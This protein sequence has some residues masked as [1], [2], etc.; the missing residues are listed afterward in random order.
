MRSTPAS[1]DTARAPAPADTALVAVRG[2]T[3]DFIGGDEETRVVHG[4]DFDIGP[5]ERMALVGESGSGKSLTAQALLRLGTQVRYGGSIHFQG[6][7]VLAMSQSALRGLRGRDVGMIFQEPMSA[8]NPLFPVG[9]QICEVLEQHQGL[10]RGQSRTR[11]LE[12]LTQTQI[13]EPERRIDH[14][15]H[16]LSGGQRQRVMIA[17]ALACQPKLLIA[18]EPTTA[19]DVTVQAQIMALLA[20]LQREFGMAVLLITHDLPQVRAFADR[21]AVMQRGRIVE[22]GPTRDLFEMPQQQ[23]TRRLIES[24]P[25]RMVTAMLDP[26]LDRE[27]APG[28]VLAVKSLACTYV[29]SA[30]WFRK[31]RVE[32]VRQVSFALAP[33]R[34]LGVVGESGSGKTTLALAIMRLL[35][36]QTRGEIQ[37]GGHRLDAMHERELRVYRRQFQM[38]FQDPFNSLSPRLTLGQILGE[39]IDLHFPQLAADERRARAE[40]A[41]AD[42]GLDSAMMSR[43]PH[44]FSGGQR[45]R[46]AI[47]RALV[48][49]PRL[50][51]L[52]EPTSALDLTVQLQVLE[53]LVN[54]QRRYHLSYLLITHDLSVIRALAHDLIVMKDGRVVEEGSV[55]RVFTAPA[56]PYTCTLLSAVQQMDAV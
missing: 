35:D 27:D 12:L 33:G 47:A 41:L 36:G 28:P 48:L 7:D 18:D 55:E 3:V 6:Q 2:L 10:T 22:Q 34:T 8:L 30:G 51:V 45:Q 31:H 17:M 20:D 32:A 52:D 1:A 39:G 14:L 19:L 4:I 24:R 49:R 38:V 9:D 29:A 43:Y 40:T 37:I 46:I 54:L 26:A 44:E 16:Q 23:V 13:R 25:Q 21:V 5:G 50:I 11:V 15:P 42:V 53:L 56:D